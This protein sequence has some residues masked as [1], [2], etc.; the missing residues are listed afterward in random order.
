MSQWR[1]GTEV[2]ITTLNLK[3]LVRTSGKLNDLPEAPKGEASEKKVSPEYEL[4]QAI[5]GCLR[6]VSVYKIFVYEIISESPF[7][8]FT[9]SFY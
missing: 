5:R 4:H 6:L 1:T 2:L 9:A 7:P 3:V 8:V